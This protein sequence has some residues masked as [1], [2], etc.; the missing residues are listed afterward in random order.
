[1]K[2][3]HIEYALCDYFLPALINDDYSGFD[4][5]SEAAI[6]EWLESVPADGH[7]D[8]VEDSGNFRYCAITELYGDTVIVRRYFPIT[9]N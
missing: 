8:V 4:D 6:R 5:Y 2:F 9:G 3:D 1:M 7:W